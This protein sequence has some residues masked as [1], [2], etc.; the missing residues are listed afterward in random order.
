MSEYWDPTHDDRTGTTDPYAGKG[1]SWWCPR[2]V[3]APNAMDRKWG[4][5]NG[6]VPLNAAVRAAAG[7]YHYHLVGGIA[8]D[9]HDHGL[10]ATDS[11]IVSPTDSLQR[12]GNLYGS[13]HAN[14]TG[15]QD[16]ATRILNSG[17][18]TMPTQSVTPRSVELSIDPTS[19]KWGAYDLTAATNAPA[20]AGNPTGYL[21]TVPR[22]VYR[23]SRAHIIELSIDPASGKWIAYDLTAA[24]NA[25]L[26]A[27]DPSGYLGTVPRVDYRD[28]RGHIIE[29]SID[30][31][32]GKW[33]AYD[34]TAAS[35]APAAS[36]DP[37]GYF[38]TVPRVVYADQG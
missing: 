9:F 31:A 36:G 3:L 12:Q 11:W 25:P 35:N 1:F 29:L 13:W 20:A 30:P 8:S 16:I 10:C 22:A 26:A 24:T 18:F 2:D 37:S 6:V 23:D 33:I 21:G 32:S 4:Y 15:Q 38:A 14:I 17:A 5:I 19:G 28:S 34:L 7:T 27:G